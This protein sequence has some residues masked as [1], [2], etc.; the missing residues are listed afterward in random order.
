MKSLKY[1]RSLKNEVGN[2][3]GKT[4]KILNSD[5]GGKYLSKRFKDH[6]KACG[7]ILEL[8]PI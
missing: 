5:Q 3:L 2:Q 8:T 1:S 4:I 7:F 6:L